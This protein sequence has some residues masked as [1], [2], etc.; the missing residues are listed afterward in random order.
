MANRILIEVCVG[1]ISAAAGALA[2]GADRIELNSALEL[3]GLTPSIGAVHA[4]CSISDKPIIAMLRPHHQ[5]FV[6]DQHDRVAILRDAELLMR[7]GMAGVA[8]GALL[9]E[10]TIDRSL[11]HEV[12]DICADRILVFHRAFD[13]LTNQLAAIEILIELGVDRILTSGG[14]PTAEA[15]LDRLCELNH[16]F[17]QFIEIL[18]AGGITQSNALKIVTATG[19][20]QIHGSFRS[21]R[22]IADVAIGDVHNVCGHDFQAI[23]A[24][25]QL[26]DAA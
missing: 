13:Q 4:L 22:S 2:A 21:T 9:D 25:R 3:D 7:T 16:R 23:T 24:T 10:A 6:Y 15:G 12:R 11:M 14:R 17:G 1:R 26:L 8:C 5:G 19:C 18:P 20:R